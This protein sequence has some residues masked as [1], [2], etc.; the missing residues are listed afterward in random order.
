MTKAILLVK[1][2]KL[3]GKEASPQESVLR[4]T[5]VAVSSVL[6]WL[7]SGEYLLRTSESLFLEVKPTEASIL[8]ALRAAAD[9]C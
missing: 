8:M 1:A 4:G 5:W 9:K 3:K 2:L 7:Q 6:L